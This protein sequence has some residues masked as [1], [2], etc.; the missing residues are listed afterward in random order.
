M[1]AMPA[2]NSG[3]Q[4]TKRQE[5]EG[6]IQT[7]KSADMN[8]CKPMTWKEILDFVENDID[9]GLKVLEEYERLVSALQVSF[10]WHKTI[11][12]TEFMKWNLFIPLVLVKLIGVNKG[13]HVTLKYFIILIKVSR[14]HRLFI[15]PGQSIS[16]ICIV[17]KYDI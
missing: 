10:L 12:C 9:F 14:K 15:G 7:L 16:L 6:E 2:L 5:V 3:R 8:T 13:R 11:R 1:I 4:Q 17:V